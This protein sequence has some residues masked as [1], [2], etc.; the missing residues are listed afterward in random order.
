MTTCQEL[1]EGLLEY[2]SD[3][4]WP[5]KR[6]EFDLHLAR[7]GSCSAYVTTYRSTIEMARAAYDPTHYAPEVPES[8]V[9][10]ILAKAPKAATKQQRERGVG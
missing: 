9:Q 10:A 6:A 2:L 8:L 5:P 7:C 3:E 4:L 1:V